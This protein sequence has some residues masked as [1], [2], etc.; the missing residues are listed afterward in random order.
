M[1]CRAVAKLIEAERRIGA[2]VSVGI[3]PA[4]DYLP[5]G[6]SPDPDGYLAFI[7]VLIDATRDQAAAYKPNLAFFEALGREGWDLLW[8]V[9]E[10]VPADALFLA[11]AKR[12]DI[13][14]SAKRYATALYE[15]LGA[16]A[17]TV[18][19]LMGRDSVEP[20]LSYA[21]KL[22]FC[23]VLTSNPGADDFLIADGTHLRI[24][25]KLSEWGAGGNVGFVVGATR[26]D[27]IRAV[28]E[29]GRSVPF[30]VP[31]VGAQGG[32]VEGVFEAG[33]ASGDA[34]WSG[35]LIHATRSLMPG[36]GEQGDVSDLVRAKMT[37]MT[38][39]VRTAAGIGVHSHG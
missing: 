17:A 28:R 26:P 14:S 11:D 23:L 5:D 36:T 38:G 25:S 21:D 35:L 18:N 37:S 29:R 32:E 12:S 30:L 7:R 10:L 2:A 6:F 20:F 22:T 34:G 15:E 8:K 33:K 16:D 39:A 24:A 3:E 4:P 19:P 27:M 9:R 1:A 31:G 13:G